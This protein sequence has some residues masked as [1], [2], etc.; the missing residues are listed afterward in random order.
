M[1]EKC[2]VIFSVSVSWHFL[3]K[4]Q[5]EHA[6]TH[7]TPRWRGS[8][9]GFYFTDGAFKCEVVVNAWQR[10]QFLLTATVLQSSHQLCKCY[11]PKMSL[12]QKNT[13][14]LCKSLQ[15]NTSNAAN[16]IRRES[17]ELLFYEHFIYFHSAKYAFKL[18]LYLFCFQT[19]SSVYHHHHL[20]FPIKHAARVSP[21]FSM[22]SLMK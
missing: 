6:H 14:F 18:E 22:N 2:N 4:A 10:E 9:T 21:P 8:I 1:S 16:I 7:K 11:S 15:R 17:E 13:D 12:I 20:G 3:S 5:M 19:S